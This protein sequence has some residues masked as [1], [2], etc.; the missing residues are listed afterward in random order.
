MKTV[1]MKICLFKI[2]I[3]K[4][5]ATFKSNRIPSITT[6]VHVSLTSQHQLK[7]SIKLKKYHEIQTI[8]AVIISCKITGSKNPNFL[9]NIDLDS[10]NHKLI[11]T[12]Q[13]M[14]LRVKTIK[15]LMVHLNK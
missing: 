8:S 6:Q 5:K 11:C 13:K 1:I 12:G 4:T 3:I 2:K 15:P 14:N 10:V 7:V 9:N